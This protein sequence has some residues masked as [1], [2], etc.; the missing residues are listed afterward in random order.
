MFFKLLRAKRDDLAG[1]IWPHGLDLTYVGCE[2][3]R[4]IVDS[5]TCCKSFLMLIVVVLFYAHE[6][7]LILILCVIMG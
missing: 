7:I 2:C 3:Y 4:V 6:V 5:Q 1:H